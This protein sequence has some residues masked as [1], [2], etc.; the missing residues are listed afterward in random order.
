MSQDIAYPLPTE[1][2]STGTRFGGI[3]ILVWLLYITDA[4]VSCQLTYYSSN[5]S[6]YCKM[7]ATHSTT[8]QY[9]CYTQQNIISS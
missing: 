5:T 9:N 1:V 8:I 3:T 4:P 2:S 7:I 6:I